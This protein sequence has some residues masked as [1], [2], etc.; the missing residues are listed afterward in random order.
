[1]LTDHNAVIINIKT[2]FISQSYMV[3]RSKF[4]AIAFILKRWTG[5]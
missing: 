2:F 1:M 4:G 5:R 3:K